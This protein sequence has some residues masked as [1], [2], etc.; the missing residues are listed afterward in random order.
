MTAWRTMP[1][2]LFAAVILRGAGKVYGRAAP[3]A[4]RLA[5]RL[6][7]RAM[8]A[9]AFRRAT[10]APRSSRTRRASRVT[11]FMLIN[12]PKP[13][14]LPPGVKLEPI[15]RGEDFILS[16]ARDYFG[17]TDNCHVVTDGSGRTE[18]LI[19]DVCDAQQQHRDIES[20]AFVKA[21]RAFIHASIEFVCWSAADSSDLPKVRSWAEFEEELLSQTVAHPADFYV[22]FAPA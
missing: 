13:V 21:T 14:D 10:A 16:V 9:L 6:A 22:H 7:P 5:R 12:T 19:D 1:S 15:A 3:G 8:D 4:G 17:N 18:P 2:G 20:T 11:Q